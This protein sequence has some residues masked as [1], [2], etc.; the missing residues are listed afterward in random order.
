MSIILIGC[1]KGGTGKT[2]IAVNLA[3]FRA[4]AGRDVLLLDTDQQGNASFWAQIRDENQVLPRIACVSKFGQGIRHEVKDLAN[5][6][7][8][9]VIDA[10]GRDSVELRSAMVVTERLYIPSK[11]SQF[12]LWTLARMSQL[13]DQALAINEHLKASIVISCASTNPLIAETSEAQDLIADLENKKIGLAKT[14]VRDRIVYR[15][16]ARMGLGV[17]EFEPGDPKAISEMQTLYQ[18]VFSD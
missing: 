6:Y 15:K 9:I 2:T 1:E 12:D 16:A 18:E 11:P 13:V 17:A 7:D 10:G 3:V 4:K 8:D 14:V 5:R